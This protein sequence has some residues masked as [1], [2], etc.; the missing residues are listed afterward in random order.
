MTL[1]RKT[2]TVL[3]CDLVGSTALGDRSD[4]EL[5]REAM[6]RYHAELRTILERHGGT[7]EKFV[8]DAAMAVFGLPQV[9]EDDALR[10]V[11]AAA[12]I[13]QAL[14]GLELQVR[15]GINTGEVVAGEGET[16]VTGDAVNVAARLEQAA[17]A[18]EILLGEETERLVHDRVSVDPVEP[19][20]LKG[21][22]ER[23]PAF[24]LLEVVP[25]VPAFTR[26][27]EAPF[28]GREKEL[29]ALES[30]LASA[31]ER[32]QPQLATIVGPPGIGKS[33]LA[34]EL[35]GRSDARVL[36]G[37][38]LSYGEGIT[39]WPLQE[40]AQQV[41]DLD[42][43]LCDDLAGVRIQAA[44]G[45]GSASSEEIAWGFRKLFEA[46]AQ[47]QPLIVVLD[48]VHWAE[49][50]LLDLI[51]YLAAFASDAPLLLLCSA[52][53]D[54]FD[55]RPE[56][57]TP[58]PNATLLT[59]EPLPEE[60]TETL[61]EEL[62][63][64][65]AEA[66]ERIVEAAE[67][68]PLFVEQ[69]VAHQ[70][71]GGNGG[72]EIPPT[73][74][75]LLAARIDRLEPPE[76]AVIERASVEGRLFHRGS[77]QALLAETERERVGGHLLTLVRKEFIRPDRSQLPGDDGFRFGHILIRDAAYGSLPKR[78]RA[79][80][81]E[82][83]ADWIEERMGEDAPE[84]ILGYHLE[85]AYRY[86]AELGAPDEALA[87]R[88]GRLLAEAGRR[89]HARNDAAA[90]R[91]LLD[92]ATDLLPDGDSEFPALLELL[93]QAVF[94]GGDL[95]RALD[96]LRR[97]QSA[98]AARQRSIELRARMGELRI[99]ILADPELDTRP[100]LEEA[101][102][103]IAELT[104]LDDAKSLAKAWHTVGMVRA[105]RAEMALM[106]E[107]EANL[108]ELA[109]R[110]GLRREA[111]EA[112]W[113]LAGSLALGPM[114]VE[115]ATRRVKQL[116]VDLPDAYPVES[117]LAI[118]YSYT[119]RHDEAREAI[120]RS[121]HM[122]QELGRRIWH[123]GLAMNAGWIA[124]LAD[125]PERVEQDLRDSA[126]VL[127]E[128]GE[129]GLRS[130]V[131]AVLA[132]VLYEL[133]QDEEAEEWTRRSEQASSV[134][135]VLSHTLWRSTRAKVLARRGE[136]AEALRLSAEAVEWARRSDGLPDLGDALFARGEVLRMLGR[137]D[138]A[139]PA[140]EEAL[141]VYERKRIV[142]SIERTTHAL[143][144]LA[145]A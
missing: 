80:L 78:E 18:G 145:P 137:L 82:R 44:L 71:E 42:A 75:A 100:V 139:R 84:E 124:L 60:Q 10:A 102:A 68:N 136:A 69:L 109:R 33:R 20:S 19:L 140:Y 96:L 25:D 23:V 77:V 2:V 52:R 104:Q 36:V 118:L 86:R 8:G 40:V 135:D 115:E 89:A 121:R 73:M 31:V 87:T 79:E 38:C 54:L 95:P 53:P 45:E 30:A 99:L 122:M 128:A 64:F 117:Y 22:A 15:I 5:L 83:F 131:T 14:E 58:K 72:L 12:E 133:G 55:R 11:S 105:M 127:D 49:P 34:R 56:W 62:A 43:V 70:A 85:Q 7:V 90:T 103:A 16:L 111:L 28:V 6:A 94:E 92:R 24:R 142:P 98:A 35:V 61:V 48:D 29:E 76:R 57:T 50:T 144:E 126:T 129:S 81:H 123:A 93:G 67:G 47:V 9:H 21:K 110:A 143:A 112:A 26:P 63:H 97:A 59:L 65:G 17:D 46:L 1:V 116:L 88:A 107:A 27:I 113:E 13:R 130:T 41:G 3:F 120:E 39:Y 101:Q 106:G 119:G 66:K 134:E 138:E 32:R 108:L 91:S 141:A 132:E 51:E 37:R 125:E 74:Q 114:P 4:P